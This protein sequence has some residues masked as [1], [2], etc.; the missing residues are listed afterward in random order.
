MKCFWWFCP[1]VAL[2]AEFPFF[3]PISTG[4]TRASSVI[5]EPSA[6]TP[7]E[8]WCRKE[9]IW[10][11]RAKQSTPFACYLFLKKIFYTYPSGTSLLAGRQIRDPAEA[12]VW[13]RY[14]GWRKDRSQDLVFVS[15]ARDLKREG[16]RESRRRRDRRGDRG[17]WRD[18]TAQRGGRGR[19][20]GRRRCERRVGDRRGEKKKEG[21]RKMSM[22][23]PDG[24]FEDR[25]KYFQCSSFSYSRLF[26]FT[27]T[28]C[29]RR[30][31]H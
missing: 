24:I 9:L 8:I 25:I 18:E 20:K 14:G 28:C 29:L 1:P 23:K 4:C 26:V 30:W 17:R 10:R 21:R 16:T 3:P 12:A 15:F 5:A 6:Q 31:M 13:R 7:A 27:N 22:F 19:W 2:K 11:L